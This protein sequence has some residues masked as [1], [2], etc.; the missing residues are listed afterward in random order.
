MAPYYPLKAAITPTRGPLNNLAKHTHTK[1]KTIV[2]SAIQIHIR[3]LKRIHSS[4]HLTLFA[5]R[6]KGYE[7]NEFAVRCPSDPRIA[8]QCDKQ[9]R[10]QEVKIQSPIITSSMFHSAH[11]Q[12]THIFSG[13]Y[14][15][16]TKI[17][18]SLGEYAVV[19]K[20][21]RTHARLCA[22]SEIQ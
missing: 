19:P 20:Q 21:P 2:F 3:N 4:D 18:S 13:N 10:K 1:T 17:L 9:E 7:V 11:Y 5:Q 12:F 15:S 8:K 22:P 6:G 14:N 16:Q